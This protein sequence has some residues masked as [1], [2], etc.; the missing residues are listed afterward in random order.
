MPQTLCIIFNL[1]LQEIV[2]LSGIKSME[3]MVS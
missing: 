2:N 3:K 1:Y